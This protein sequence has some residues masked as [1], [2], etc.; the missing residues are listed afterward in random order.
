MRRPGERQGYSLAEKFGA[1][2]MLA[3]RPRG[4]RA[5]GFHA[6]DVILRLGGWREPNLRHSPAPMARVLIAGCGYVGCELGKALAADDH[7]VW[8]LRRNVSALPPEI[9]PLPAD[10]CRPGGLEKLPVDFDFAVYAA[11]PG[12]WIA[13]PMADAREVEAAYRTV[14]LDGLGNL[15]RLLGR[16]ERAPRRL[17]FTSS[18]A[19]YGQRRGEWVDERAHTHPRRY[20][21]EIL[22]LAEGLLRAAKFPSV[23]VRFGG[24]YGPGRTRLIDH[25]RT[26]EALLPTGSPHYT[27]RIHRDDAAGALQ[28]LLMLEATESCYLGVDCEPVSDRDLLVWMA[29]RLGVAPSPRSGHG[30]GASDAQGR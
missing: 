11:S 19:V 25:V 1:R 21:G 28:H 29:E 26:G 2:L 5:T 12:S 27:N 20:S 17:I 24:I 7:E 22:L 8:G 18:T 30:L 3:A 6:I 15:I 4:I 13:R 9:Q 16:Q 23:A 14:Y 10:L